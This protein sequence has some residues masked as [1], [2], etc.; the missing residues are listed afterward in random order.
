[1]I[2]HPYHLE[3]RFRL[4]SPLEQNAIDYR[5]IENV[6]EFLGIVRRLGVTHVVRESELT[7]KRAANPVGERVTRLWDALLARSEKIAETDAGTLY[8]LPP[9]LAGAKWPGPV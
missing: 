8:R 5:R 4:A 7:E 1:M 9:A 3:R 2:P 6:D